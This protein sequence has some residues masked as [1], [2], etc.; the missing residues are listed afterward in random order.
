V[1]PS[2]PSEAPEVARS[3][4]NGCAEVAPS[5]PS[6]PSGCAEVAPS[7]PS[8]GAEVAPS[9]PSGTDEV[10]YR[11]CLDRVRSTLHSG[12]CDH[13]EVRWD[14][15]HL[16]NRQW[17]TLLNRIVDHLVTLRANHTPTKTLYSTLQSEFQYPIGPLAAAINNLPLTS[18][19]H[20]EEGRENVVLCS[21]P[22]LR[23]KATSTSTS[24]QRPPLGV[25][26]VGEVPKEGT[27]EGD[28]DSEHEAASSVEQ[29]SSHAEVVALTLIVFPREKLGLTRL[30]SRQNSLMDIA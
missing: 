2:A 7:G 16:K 19:G 22:R 29:L 13:G 26:K 12:G 5:G 8:G 21:N 6:G 9:T 27:L 23:S 14:V 30:A 18:D 24:N 20:L 1:T 15:G 28:L 25:G 3:G 10:T 17:T 11:T 4:P